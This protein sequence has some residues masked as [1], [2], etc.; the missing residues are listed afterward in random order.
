MPGATMIKLTAVDYFEPY[1]WI[2]G[3]LGLSIIL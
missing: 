3:Y 2:L 1:F